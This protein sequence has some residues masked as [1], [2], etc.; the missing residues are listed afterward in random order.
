MEVVFDAEVQLAAVVVDEPAAA[1]YGEG[2]RF[3]LLGHAEDADV[4]GSQDVLAA[5]GAGDLYVV[6]HVSESGTGLRA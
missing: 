5:P 1:A 2:G 6:N 4:E 3:G